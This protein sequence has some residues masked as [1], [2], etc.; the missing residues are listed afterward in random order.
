ME[1]PISLYLKTEQ[2]VHP[3]LRVVA[4]SAIIFAEIIE[5]TA[6]AIDPDL[7]VVVEVVSGSEGSFGL[8][9]L[10]KVATKAKA[11]AADVK[12]GV[13]DGW[14]KHEKARFLT[15]YVA[16]RI[17]DN[18][19][20]WGQDQIMDWM[21]SDD[22]PAEVRTMSDE[23][24]KLLAKDIAEEMR[25]QPDDEKVQRLHGQIAKDKRIGAIGITAR[26]QP[27]KKLLPRSAFVES[28]EDELP[29]DR[30]RHERFEALLISPVLEVGERRWKFRGPYGE[31][32]APINDKEWLRSA[33][34][35]ETNLH[36]RGGLILDV[37]I[38]V[39]EKLLDAGVWEIERRTVEKVHGWREGPVQG[40]FLA[41]GS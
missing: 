40:D 27:A 37:E 19:I 6:R 1:V 41:S 16:V 10:S 32:G 18:T 25:R 36:L 8:N 9:T 17:L 14:R 13:L 22:A 20:S 2:G 28:P 12:Q 5:S 24:R 7:V 38:D 11:K 30:I 35:G 21:A 3:D 33:V 26:P 31:F 34:T 15:I 23:E 39:Y 29:S 4:R